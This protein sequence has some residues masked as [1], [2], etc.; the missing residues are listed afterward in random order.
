MLL[1]TAASLS[2]AS[3]AALRGKLDGTR[4]VGGN[5]EI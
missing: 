2:E 4:S 3:L 1:E 5:V